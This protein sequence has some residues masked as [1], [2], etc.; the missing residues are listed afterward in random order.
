[1]KPKPTS[2]IVQ[3]LD[4]PRIIGT[5]TTQSNTAGR[6]SKARIQ[7]NFGQ[8]KTR[9]VTDIKLK[10][11]DRATLLSTAKRYRVESLT[12]F[13]E[14]CLAAEDRKGS[15]QVLFQIYED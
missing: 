4:K 1:M 8:T 11:K 10:P 3:K 9:R 15:E 2:S 5:L 7:D 6:R 14:G 13:L 12:Q